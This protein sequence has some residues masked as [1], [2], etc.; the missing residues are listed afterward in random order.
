MKTKLSEK[1]KEVIALMRT[2]K[3][4]YKSQ[5]LE[6]SAGFNGGAKISISLATFRKLKE[7][8]LLRELEKKNAFTLTYFTLS[9]LGKLIPPH[10]HKA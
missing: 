3:E 10:P 4:I 6:P 7:L 9:E 2:G 8:G 1:Q 5:G